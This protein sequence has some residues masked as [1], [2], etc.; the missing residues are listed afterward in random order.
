MKTDIQTVHSAHLFG[1]ILENKYLLERGRIVIT[2]H[3]RVLASIKP[4]ST[5]LMTSDRIVQI[6]RRWEWMDAEIWNQVNLWFWWWAGN[7]HKPS[8]SLLWKR[9]S[10]VYCRHIL[11]VCTTSHIRKCAKRLPVWRG[12]TMVLP[13]QPHWPQPFLWPPV[14]SVICCS[15]QYS[16]LNMRHLMSSIHLSFFLYHCWDLHKPRSPD[17]IDSCQKL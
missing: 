12:G 8:V 13:E 5:A 14:I 17:V 11:Q 1:Q 3:T 7:W 4:S 6:K 16:V 15:D 2:E 10:N 9:T